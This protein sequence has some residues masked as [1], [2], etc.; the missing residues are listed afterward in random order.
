M[1][2][3]VCL[4]RQAGRGVAS[5]LIG[6]SYGITVKGQSCP[7]AVHFGS[8]KVI[9]AERT[10]LRGK[11]EA[12]SNDPVIEHITNRSTARQWR[13]TTAA[14]T[15]LSDAEPL[16]STV[17]PTGYHI[18]LVSVVRFV[19]DQ[20]LSDRDGRVCHG[21]ILSIDEPPGGDSETSTA[22]SPLK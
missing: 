22:W 17:S 15:R 3:S 2:R 10:P 18:A 13:L 11:P 12:F 20:A 9:Q 5:G 1:H 14:L 4:I 6:G 19:R 16:A 21:E 8:S 7:H